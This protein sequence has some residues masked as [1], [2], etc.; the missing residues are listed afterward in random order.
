VAFYIF[1]RLSSEG[2]WRDDKE[3]ALRLLKDE[4]VYILHGSGF[5]ERYGKNHFRSVFLP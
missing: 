5:G 4:G 3:F 1:P 2:N